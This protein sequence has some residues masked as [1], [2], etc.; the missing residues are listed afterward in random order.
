MLETIEKKRREAARCRCS[1][2]NEREGKSES[3][4]TREGIQD[5]EFLAVSPRRSKLNFGS[6][7]R[8]LPYRR[9]NTVY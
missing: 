9:A 6:L 8:K 7:P 1:I 5:Q 2:K 3:E 4:R